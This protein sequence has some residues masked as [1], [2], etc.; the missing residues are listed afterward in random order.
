MAAA[1]LMGLCGLA[2]TVWLMP[3]MG[4]WHMLVVLATWVLVGMLTFE[5]SFRRS[6]MAAIVYFVVMVG[7]QVGIHLLAKMKL[8][9]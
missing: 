7:V 8:P 2:S 3:L 4:H 9:A 1:I 6:L 5:F